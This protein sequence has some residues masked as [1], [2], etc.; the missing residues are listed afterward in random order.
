E[1]HTFPGAVRH[2][3]HH[4]LRGR[5]H[6]AQRDRGVHERRADAQ[7][8]QPGPGHLRA[9]ARQPRRPDSRLLRDGGRR[10]RGRRRTRDH[11]DDLPHPPLGLGRRRKPPEVL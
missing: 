8:R 2:L 1:R 11:H 3:V 10:R 9:C 4:R 6:Q 5:A 7:R